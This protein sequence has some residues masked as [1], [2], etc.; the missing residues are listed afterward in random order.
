MIR[1]CAVNI[2][3][4]MSQDQY[5]A[6][7]SYVSEEKR[8][9]IE[10]FHFPADA[11]RS[12]LGDVL[13]RYLIN[14]NLKVSNDG[15]TFVCNQYGKPYLKGF[16]SFHFNISHSGDWVLCGASD[17]QI[18]I[19]I[20]QVKPINTNIAK[21]FFSRSE[22]MDLIS[23]PIHEQDDYFY[24]L[25]TLKESYI[26]YRGKGLSIPL[27]SFSFML[28]SSIEITSEDKEKPYF[29]TYDIGKEYK[30]SICSQEKCGDAR[31][32]FISINDIKIK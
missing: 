17:K 4:K 10:K 13:S 22:Y 25:W 2:T 32:E 11:T 7:L 5:E 12:L 30:G 21:R 9:K 8:E 24:R 6:F 18:G 27:D 3:E 26:K 1:L 20:E 29:K 19:D 23:R 14:Y 31:I 15:I 16:S 28:G